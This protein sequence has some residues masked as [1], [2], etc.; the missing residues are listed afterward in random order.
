MTDP[1]YQTALADICSP[2][3]ALKPP[4]RISVSQGAAES[5]FIRQPGGYV[6]PWSAD[7]TPYMVEPMDMLASRR[8]EAVCFVGPARSGKTLGLLDGWLAHVIVNDPGDTLFVTMSQDKAREYSKTRVDRMLRYSPHLSALKSHS[9]QDD[10]THD[11]LFKHGMWLKLGWPTVSNMS[12]SEY[13][14]VGLTDYDR[15]PKNL[16]GEG[17]AF[18][19]GLKRTT[20][21]LSRGMCAVESS[22]GFPLTDPSWR[23]ATLHEAPPVEGILGIYNRSDR[24]RWYWKC[25]D[26][27]E[28]FEASPGLEMFGLPSDD[29][30]IETVREADLD[31]L[32][33]QYN[34]IVCPHCGSLIAHRHKNELNLRSKFLGWLIDGQRRTVDDELIGSA[35]TSTIAGYWLGG[36]AAAYQSWKSLIMRH[37]QGLREFAL[38]GSEET[39]KTTCNTDQGRPY[40]SRH[41]VNAARGTTGPADRKE[42]AM[43]RYVVP[44]ETRLLVAAVDVQGGT[45]ARFE[46]QVHAIGPHME[47]W[48][49]NRFPI[50]LSKRPG[51]GTEFAPI[52]PAAYPEDW[53]ALTEEVVRSTYRTPLDG[54]ELRIKLIVVDTGGEDGVTANAYAWYRR[55]KRENLAGRVM[56]YKGAS[57][58]TAP[59][60][61]LA[62]VGSRN[63]KEKGDV[64]LYQ[65]NPNLLSDAVSHG[66]KR[67]TPG[68]GFIHFP[69]WL[70]TAF[71]DELTAEVRSASGVWQQI[72]KRNEAFDLC[73]MIRA[74]CLRLGLD[75]IKRWEVVPDWGKPL[76]ENSEL[77]TVEDRR[78]MK[79]NEIV[80]FV[81][82]VEE[83]PAPT[84]RT[85][86]QRR[87]AQSA[88]LR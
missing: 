39:L 29:E 78:E 57:S 76:A 18:P 34:R 50:K 30:L 87:V 42:K 75:K 83:K 68:P 37:L 73:R 58:K 88:Y 70:P 63:A 74:G 2:Y 46:V 19:L 53:D 4:R 47:Q 85:V 59:I 40:L 67:E 66:M 55:L 69:S 54:K 20:T 44:V 61:R 7:E 45:N 71:F 28:W 86:R 41:L 64:P 13:R 49:V 8:H 9:A 1:H 11:K 43:E 62:R 48:L 65:C 38:S 21:F 6:G 26:C 51:M 31:K 72:R 36:V 16:D 17:A 77:I 60:L 10:N 56:L 33:N 82:A 22:P 3:A 79:A 23:P 5:L 80:A 24:R 15:F 25:F 27:R 14:Y 35:M 84:Q 12:Q 32:A 52:D 81:P